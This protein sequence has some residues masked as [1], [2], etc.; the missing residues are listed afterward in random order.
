MARK[1]YKRVGIRKDKNLGDL[2]N[3]TDALNNLID[4]LVDDAR[5]TFV[6]EDLNALRTMS[7]QR[8][9]NGVYSTIIGSK[10]TY[11]NQNGINLEYLPRITY[12]N[13]FDQFKVFAG[14]P[15]VDGGNGLTAKYFD[16]TNVFENTIDIFSGFP[17]KVDNFWEAGNFSFTDKLIPELTTV[18]GGVEWEG[19]F[20]PTSTG[21]H[22]FSI[23]S[24]GCFT[25]DFEPSVISSGS[26][27]SIGF[28]VQQNA[29]ATTNTISFSAPSYP[30]VT[31]S[32]SS[33]GSTSRM[34]YYDVDYT[35]QGTGGF[36]ILESG[37]KIGLDDSGGTG[38]KDYDYDDLT[39]LASRGSF[40]FRNNT[41]YYRL[42]SYDEIS[43][44]GLST[45]IPASGT[46]GANSLTIS[47]TSN[48]KY[49]AIGQTVS[50]TGIAT[51]ALVNAINRTTGVISL[52]PPT[53]EPFSVKTTFSNNIVFRKNLGDSTSISYTTPVLVAYQ[54]YP[55]RFRYFIPSA[56]DAT[57]VE[58]YINFDILYPGDSSFSNLSYTKL[59]S[60]DY[61]F[62]D[63]VGK[64]PVYV[65]GSI[66]SGGGTI[67][68]STNSNNYVR[69]STNKR[70]DV[71][72]QPKT[73]ISDITKASTTATVTSSRNTMTISNTSNIEIGNYVYGNGIANG[74]R[75]DEIRINSSIVLNKNVDLILTA[76]SDALSSNLRVAL[77]LNS[78][79]GITDRTSSFTGSPNSTTVLNY[80]GG[81]TITI[82]SAQSKFYGFSARKPIELPQVNVFKESHIDV[83]TGSG[84]Q[85]GTGNYCIEG[86]IYTEN[87]NFGDRF[88]MDFLFP[89]SRNGSVTDIA[90]GFVPYIQILSNAIRVLTPSGSFVCQTGG[91]LSANRW[92]HIAVTRS[93]STVRIFV[94][95][96]LQTSGSDGSNYY[97]YEY[98]LFSSIR[99]FSAGFYFQ[100]VR[101]YAGAAKYTSNFTPPSSMF[102]Y[103]STTVTG[104]YRF[105]DHRGFVKQAIG[106]SS[107]G[108]ITLNS[109]D[110]TSLTKDMIV[111]APG[112]Q[113]FTRIQTIPSSKTL[114]I[115]PSQSVGAGTTFYFYYSKGLI[116][117]GLTEYCIP[118]ETKCMLITADTP[119]GSTII[120]VT[121]S[122]G[123]GNGWSVQGFQFA[124]GTTVSGAPTSATSIRISTPTTSNLVSGANFTVS[125]ASG[126]R[127]L[128][129]PPT[130]TSPP[131]NPTLEG[132]ETTSAA[133]NL[134]LE[135]GNISFD[136]LKAVISESNITSYTSTDKSRARLSITT[137]SGTFKILCS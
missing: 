35:V 20:I 57:N 119:A 92:H 96:I 36:Q 80:S 82:E 116:N 97:G 98:W 110:T 14:D 24:S 72:Y 59:Y 78:E 50:G 38:T 73:S 25:F 65:S 137:P 1:I 4:T 13:Q 74:T 85:I 23:N 133:P 64:F 127:T 9:T 56:S 27:V 115:T 49:V 28:N 136:S 111:Y 62:N 129:C 32:P 134:R 70:F 51:G 94:D 91:A 86:W 131:F 75:V 102:Q 95:G 84:T 118:A 109:G 90:I 11:T 108:T 135:S 53:G 52:T 61:P 58:R 104:T 33:L 6:S 54:K 100:D 10:T 130:D 18:N 126:D 42:S 5:S 106:E 121:D 112:F 125:S 37:S 8:L 122:T 83:N 46:V 76:T 93:G 22:T 3:T 114:T 55:I 47:S 105:M 123:V 40:F 81:G 45:S 7:S 43:R 113:Q 107:S 30:T 63:G 120:P 99:N 124:S 29:A 2:S 60:L 69:V 68:G 77:P 31:F 34:I 101:I 26:S 12:Q 48:V 21:Q 89:R 15:F 19:Y 67:G 17:I 66:L 87:F 79:F 16:Y 117:N 44:I 88:E 41:F 39:V 128:C 132:L 103:I 71:R